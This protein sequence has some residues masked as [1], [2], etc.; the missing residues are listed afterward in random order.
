MSKKSIP[1][2]QFTEVFPPSIS[3]VIKLNDINVYNSFHS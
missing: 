1:L 3:C 2:F